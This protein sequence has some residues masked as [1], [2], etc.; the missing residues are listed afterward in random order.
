MFSGI[1]PDG[2]PVDFK[3]T[4]G[5]TIEGVVLRAEKPVPDALV[6]LVQTDRDAG[7]FLGAETIAADSQ[8]HFMFVNVPPDQPFLVFGKMESLRP[9]GAAEYESVMVGHDGTIISLPPL[10]VVPGRTIRGRVIL[11]TGAPIPTGARL[12]V[13]RDDVWDYTEALLPAD[14]M[15]VI[16]DLPHENIS[17]AVRIPGFVLSSRNALR[18]DRGARVIQL[19][20]DQEIPDLTI[21]LEPESNRAK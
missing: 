14:G 7:R 18:T 19:E 11:T 8:G 21:L 1:R 20:A 16:P 6:G 10:Q 12:T 5:A 9:L 3:M 2:P 13:S 4:A 15:F 17:L